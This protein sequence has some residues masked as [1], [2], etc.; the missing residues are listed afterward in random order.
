[1]PALPAEPL[2]TS[3]HARTPRQKEADENRLLASQLPHSPNDPPMIPTHGF[4]EADRGLLSGG[5]TTS[6]ARFDD[7]YHNIENSQ[8]KSISQQAQGSRRT[9]VVIVEEEPGMATSP[10]SVIP[11]HQ[12]SKSICLSFANYISHTSLNIRIFSKTIHTPS[13]LPKTS[14]SST[15]NPPNQLSPSPSTRWKA[16]L[17]R[18]PAEL[19][20]ST[21]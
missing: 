13:P 14:K 4:A 19:R 20:I 15:K 9:D 11:P 7:V 2:N 21:H 10:R 17:P 3:S 6:T 16:T 12:F 5:T 18:G 8:R 1:M